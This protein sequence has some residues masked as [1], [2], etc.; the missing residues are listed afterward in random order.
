MTDT[1]LFR[2]ADAQLGACE[3]IA[4]MSVKRSAFGVGADRIVTELFRLS[5]E[6]DAA[7][8]A[9][10]ELRVLSA[11]AGIGALTGALVERMND[12]LSRSGFYDIET[13]TTQG[14]Y[15]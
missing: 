9:G 5:A 3:C 15:I 1:S 12:S 2:P 8:R 6:I 7:V 13:G 4:S 14:G 10:D 11:T